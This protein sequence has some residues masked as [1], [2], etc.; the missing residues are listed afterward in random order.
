M[1]GLLIAGDLVPVPGLTIIPPASH[2][3][4]HW[5]ALDPGDYRARQGRPHFIL[6]HTTGGHWP[7]PVLPGAGPSGHAELIAKMWSGQDR[8][9]GRRIHSAAPVLIDFDGVIYI[10]GDLWYCAAYHAE[11]ANDGSIGVEHCTT[12]RGEIY[13]ATIDASAVFHRVL[14]QQIHTPHQVHG[15]PYRNAPLARCE[16]G[17]KTAEHDGRVQSRCGDITGIIQH[18]DQTSERGRGDAGDALVAAHVAGGAEALDYARGQD[19]ELGRARQSWL[20]AHG[21]QLVV[22]GLAGPASLAEARRQG[23]ARWRDVPGGTARAVT[24]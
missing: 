2:G 5:A 9:D 22:D 8:G 18:R 13:Q 15:V 23:F 17:R 3:G 11:L 19:L 14:C 24:P 4:P 12:P 21:G 10:L 1:T 7:Q 6:D 16:T 20:N